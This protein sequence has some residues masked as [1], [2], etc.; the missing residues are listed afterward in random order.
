MTLIKSTAPENNAALSETAIEAK[1]TLLLDASG[2]KTIS[3]AA[4]SE[5]AK[6][7]A[8]RINTHL[9]D[10]EKARVAVKEPF[11]SI[12]REIDRIARDHCAELSAELRRISLATGAYEAEQVRI[13]Q[14][15]AAKARRE[16]E[17]AE[18]ER[19]RQIA[20]AD[21][22]RIE[23]ESAGDKL[24]A[25]EAEIRAETAAATPPPAATQI[26]VP[27]KPSG[28]RMELQ[29]TVDDIRLLLAERPQ[30]VKLEPDMALIRAA[31][32]AGHKLPGVSSVE[33]P[34]LS[35]R[36]LK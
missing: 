34:V 9:K 35:R 26:A 6:Q 24:A 2:I 16:A 30:Y 8:T 21:K 10:I 27:I 1:K 13:A 18:R 4:D 20:E 3:C 32:T 11:L 33:V 19:Q 17:A 23:A 5:A 22:K 29:I 7:T 15:A 14:E 12:G 36:A 28:V 25:L 31:I